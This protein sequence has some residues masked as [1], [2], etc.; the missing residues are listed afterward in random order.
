P[1]PEAAWLAASEA[2]PEF[3]AGPLPKALAGYDEVVSGVLGTTGKAILDEGITGLM[4]F[5]VYPRYWGRWKSPELQCKGKEPPGDRWDDVFWCGTWTDYHN[6]TATAVLRAMRT[7]EVQWLD[8]IAFPGAVRTL[9]TQIM[10]CGPDE[11]W[12]YCGQSPAGYGGYRSDFNSSHAYF[13][14][15]YLYY[16]LTGD[17]LVVDTLRQ[18]G[19]TMRRH[20]CETRGPAPVK[21]AQAQDGPGG[22]ACAADHPLGKASFTGRVGGQWLAAFHFLGL[23]S[24]DPSFLEDFKSGLARAVTLQYAELEK[25]GRRYGFLGGKVGNGPGGSA[26]AGP[27]WTNGFYDAE[28]LYRLM[29][30]T[31]DAPLGKPAVRPSQ[32]LA[33]VARTLAGID[34]GELAVADAKGGE[35]GTGQGEPGKKR[36]KDAWPRLLDYRWEGPRVGGRLAGVTAKDRDLYGP[37][38]AGTAAL[39]VRAGRLTGDPGLLKAGEERTRAAIEASRGEAVPLGKLQGQY[40][41]RLHAAVAGL[42]AGPI[43][44]AKPAR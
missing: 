20:M 4:T 7:G 6:T 41:N 26:Q 40:L 28:N 38:K 33:A 31:G 13:E 34:S 29:V 15:L 2:V 22:P 8:E 14:N 27:L 42:A 16:W 37:E 21:G 39:L 17:S 5:G 35:K 25:D 10:Q 30:D 11:A 19:E 18:G 44:P 23:A 9:H 1:W 32:V 3:P 43:G 36:E 24:D 12:F